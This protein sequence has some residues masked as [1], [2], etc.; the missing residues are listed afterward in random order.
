MGVCVDSLLCGTGP[1]SITNLVNQHIFIPVG[2][3]LPLW[4]V[5]LGKAHWEKGDSEWDSRWSRI[6]PSWVIQV[7]PKTRKHGKFLCPFNQKFGLEKRSRNLGNL[8]KLKKLKYG[9]LLAAP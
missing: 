3:A 4:E 1:I 5:I 9:R 7:S 6:W 8:R 2:E